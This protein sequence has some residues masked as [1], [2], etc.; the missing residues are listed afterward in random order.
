M[1]TLINNGDVGVE[2]R[3]GCF[4][5][6]CQDYCCL[7]YCR[8]LQEFISTW[9]QY[10]MLPSYNRINKQNYTNFYRC[11]YKSSHRCHYYTGI[12]YHGG[13]FASLHCLSFCFVLWRVCSFHFSSVHEPEKNWLE[14]L[15]SFENISHLDDPKA[16]VFHTEGGVDDIRYAVLKH[17]AKRG[18]QVR[19]HSLDVIQWDAFV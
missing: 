1:V 13:I 7:M 4:A 2:E 5:I 19:V 17:P 18:K 16:V 15:Y 12:C 6:R 9:L 11:M 14:A 3:D 10:V 8:Y